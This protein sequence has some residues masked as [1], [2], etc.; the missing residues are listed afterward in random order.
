MPRRLREE[1]TDLP[2]LPHP[3][4]IV[5][6]PELEAQRAKLGDPAAD[7][8]FT[9]LQADVEQVMDPDYKDYLDH[10]TLRHT[11]WRSREGAF[12]VPSTVEGLS[13]VYGVTGDRRY[14]DFAKAVVF[15]VIRNG[16]ADGGSGKTG[17]IGGGE[18][19]HYKGWRRSPDHDF[20]KLSHALAVFYDLCY[21]TLTAD[22]RRE[23]I[24]YAEECL[25]IAYDIRALIVRHNHNNRGSRC[26]MGNGLLALAVHG[27]VDFDLVR[28][29]V[30][31]AIEAAEAYA[32]FAYG[33]DGAPFEGQMYGG[34]PHMLYTFGRALARRGSRDFSKHWNIREIHLHLLYT[35]LPTRDAVAPIGD[36]HEECRAVGSLAVAAVTGNPVARW[37]YDAL[38]DE[39]EFTA[40]G[41]YVSFYYFDP[42]IT[43]VS[44]ADAGLPLSRHFRERG[45]VCLKSGWEEEDALVTFFSGRQQWACHR[46]DD[47][48]SFI[49][50]A[51]G[52]RFAWDGG[53]GSD[54]GVGAD[55][56]FRR[57]EVHNSILID[58]DGQN[59]YDH[60]RWSRGMIANF[61]DED[62]HAHALGDA[63]RCYGINGWIERANRHIYFKRR[64]FVYLVVL[65][66]VVVDG[67]P[68][69]V[70]WNFVTSPDNRIDAETPL[71]I[72][73]H[74]ARA[75]M[76]LLI[77]A[78][79]DARSE[80]DRVGLMPRYQATRHD[81]RV[82]FA[83][84]L[85]PLAEG[86]ESSAFD[87]TFEDQ[88]AQIS[89]T[90]NDTVESL[91]FESR[92]DDTTA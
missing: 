58:G 73:V 21:D 20:G 79:G 90:I 39:E 34:D 76:R 6:A 62:D 80:I 54:T 29:I 14:A 8:I 71:D 91:T 74:G 24:S 59:G 64:P 75:K 4:L 5:D 68:H 56:Q 78:D 1:I 35:A 69:D 10:D 45:L 88:E 33:I 19:E 9:R 32:Y 25:T 7:K 17:D 61:R 48:N 38:Y 50:F 55:H 57:T 84:L 44:P 60:S 89:V 81:S 2:V 31:L 12:K 13:F 37:V 51:L 86:I 49:F 30:H 26:A 41:P 92:R 28:W 27:E 18:F 87:A 47:Q 65:D 16:L 77:V 3:S 40:Y 83:A 53:Y 15:A 36:C 42:A 85:L 46:Q 23:F 70:T 22:E 67:T 63:S 66:E 52:E 82:R 11:L 72:I 43:P